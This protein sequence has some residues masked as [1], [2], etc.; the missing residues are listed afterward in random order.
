MSR[1]ITFPG[2]GLELTVNPVL[3]SITDSFGIHWY[4]AIIAVGF[5][6]AV[7]WCCHKSQSLGIQQDKLIDMLFFAVPLGIIGARLYYVLFEFRSTY[8]VQGD[9][10]A[11]LVKIVRI[12][13]G[14]LAIYGG[15]LA[16]VLTALVYC[17]VRRLP[18]LT[19][20]DISAMGLLIGQCI[21]RW[22][23]F[24]NVEAFGSVTSVPWRMAGPNVANYLLNTGQIDS[25]AYQEIVDGA[26][27]VHP[28][29][30]YESMWN[31]VGFLLI[32]LVL[33]P[34]RR[35]DGQ[36]FFSYI[37]W[38]GLGR[39]WIEGLRSDSLY[40]PGTPLRV[41]QLLAL[42]SAVAALVWLAYMLL[43]KKPGPEQLYVNRIQQTEESSELLTEKENK[44]QECE[45]HG[46]DS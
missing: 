16:S 30:F 10:L 11:T 45:D 33:R 20:A 43:V 35:F 29:F 28:T 4:G 26:L 12:W 15:I 44:E 2:L 25:T 38:Y 39:F 34:R 27:G 32:A 46:E 5:L 14:G 17:R 23:N 22:G 36:M 31:L 40:I 13:D 6:L 19:V 42:A 24:V 37:A 41:S 8:Y 7:L 9:P 3:L 18:F 21:G 1:T